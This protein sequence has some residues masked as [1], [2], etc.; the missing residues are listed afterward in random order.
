MNPYTQTIT[1]G[2]IIREFDVN[3]PTDE[4]IWHRDAHDRIVEIVKGNGWK[5]QMDNQIPIELNEGM[6][7]YIPKE[8]YHRI[9]KGNT[10]LVIK[11]KE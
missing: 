9:G 7:L 10:K 4:L 6:I 3:I 8:T 5:F 11:I 1:D 2:Y